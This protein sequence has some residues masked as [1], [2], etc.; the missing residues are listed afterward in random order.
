MHNQTSLRADA[1]RNRIRILTAAE[2][3]FALKGLG[4]SAEEIAR[5]A[6]VGIGTL[7]RHFATIEVLRDAVFAGRMRR[8]ADRA[9]LASREPDPGERSSSSAPEWSA[10]IPRT[11]GSRIR[12]PV[13]DWTPR[14]PRPA[15]ATR[16]TRR[17]PIFLSVPSARA[18]YDPM[19]TPPSS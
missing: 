12:S 18:R 9:D 19:S 16:C 14:P 6:G 5:I 2:A 10:R 3:V 13:R 4:A 11:R 7:Y 8:L 17:S 15:P 1:R